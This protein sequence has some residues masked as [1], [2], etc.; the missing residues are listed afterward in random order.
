MKVTASDFHSLTAHSQDVPGPNK[1]VKKGSKMRSF[2]IPNQFKDSNIPSG[3]EL[4][5]LNILF[6]LECTDDNVWLFVDHVRLIRFHIVSRG[7]VWNADDL[8][9]TSPVSIETSF[10]IRRCS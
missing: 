6:A 9:A 10:K 7:H 1:D 3:D 4:R 2:A 8:E 5:R